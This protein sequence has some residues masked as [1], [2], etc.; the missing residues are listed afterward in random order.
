MNCESEV[1]VVKQYMQMIAR[2]KALDRCRDE[3]GFVFSAGNGFCGGYLSSDL[4]RAL[5]LDDSVR[6]KLVTDIR[7]QEHV[8]LDNIG[9]TKVKKRSKSQKQ[10]LPTTQPPTS[11]KPLPTVETSPPLAAEAT[12]TSLQLERI[13]R[14]AGF[15]ADS[16]GAYHWGRCQQAALEYG[17]VL[18]PKPRNHY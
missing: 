11:A 13:R 7:N 15:I 9:S 16:T 8:N 3:A 12:N 10:N 2:K 17:G 18:S 14:E 4:R 1:Y 6:T 5:L